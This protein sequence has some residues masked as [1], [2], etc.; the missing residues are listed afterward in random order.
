MCAVAAFSAMAFCASLVTN[1]KVQYLSFDVKDAVIT[2]AS[3][4]YGP[5]AAVTMSLI[6]AFLEFV[7]FG[8]TGIVG[9]LM[10]FISTATFTV[11]ASLI[12]KYRRSLSGAIISLSAAVVLYIP[13]MMIANLL[14]TPLYMPVTVDF[15]RE[16]IPVFLLPFNIAKALMNSALVMLIY[17]PISNLTKRLGISVKRSRDPEERG[18]GTR[19]DTIIMMS[20]AT[21]VFAAALVIFII[22][23][24]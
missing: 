13:V 3:F 5:V 2:V 1:I 10:D 18:H 20:I 22:L 4:I 23:M 16:Q 15:V 8:G 7:T 14:F 9:A 17:K 12:Y 21:A 11:T 6:T 24:K 19:R